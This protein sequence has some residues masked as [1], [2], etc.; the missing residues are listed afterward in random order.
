MRKHLA[1]FSRIEA[2]GT[3]TDSVPPPTAASFQPFQAAAF[4]ELQQRAGD[5][6]FTAGL[7][8]DAFNGRS[9]EEQ[10]LSKT[11]V[12]LGPCLA[13]SASLGGATTVA[14]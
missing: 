5:T 1:T 6:T 4:V 11:R 14:S 12:A 10:G 7:R 2:Y 3:A 13:F 9:V 8:A